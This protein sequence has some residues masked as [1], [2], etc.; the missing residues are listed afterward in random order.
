[1]VEARNVPA[2]LGALLHTA[3]SVKHEIPSLFRTHLGKILR[4]LSE[5]LVDETHAP[6]PN[7]RSRKTSTSHVI[8]PALNISIVE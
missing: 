8:V 7:C 5:V 6:K 3:D 4:S 2:T 1:M